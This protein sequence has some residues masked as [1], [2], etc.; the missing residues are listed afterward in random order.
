M[1]RFAMA[2]LLLVAPATAHA[3][4]FTMKDFDGAWSVFLD[5]SMMALYYG[6]NFFI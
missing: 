4:T 5:W 6:L 3:Y 2:A 1:K